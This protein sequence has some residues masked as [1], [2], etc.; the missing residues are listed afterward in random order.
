M[1]QGYF[2]LA[3]PYAK[4]AFGHEAAFKDASEQAALLL[5]AGIPVFSPISHSHPIALYGNLEKTDHKLW[6]HI[7]YQILRHARGLIMLKLPGWEYS[8]G[9]DQEYRWFTK[10]T[11]Q[12][13]YWM[14]P[15]IVPE[16]LLQV[17]N[18][19]TSPEIS[20]AAHA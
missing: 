1:I 3:S 4:Y 2:Y 18:D 6:L 19:E 12:P 17:V 15:G 8:H 14:I 13:I 16:T 7:D 11:Q 10:N 5:N 20:D 9:M